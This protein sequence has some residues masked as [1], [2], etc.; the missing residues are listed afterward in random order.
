[1]T[2]TQDSVEYHAGGTPAPDASATTSGA[3]R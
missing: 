3:K 2:L 1:M